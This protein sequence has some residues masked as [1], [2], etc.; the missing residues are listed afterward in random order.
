MTTGKEAEPRTPTTR[1][2]EV[3]HDPPGDG[4]Y[5][6]S[7]GAAQGI[8]LFSGTDR[9]RRVRPTKA[10]FEP[11]RQDSSRNWMAPSSKA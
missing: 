6:S 4:N 10:I 9:I 2:S 8:E 1:E 3:F 7:I 11:A 5:S